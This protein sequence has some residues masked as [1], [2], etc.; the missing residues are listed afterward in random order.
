MNSKWELKEH[1]TGDLTVTI[2]G[3]TWEKAQKTASGLS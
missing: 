2:E 1:S 3:E